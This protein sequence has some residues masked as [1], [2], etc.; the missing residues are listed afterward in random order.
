MY[1]L[2]NKI[3]EI[4]Q[5]I[6][7]FSIGFGLIDCF[8]GYRHFKFIIALNGFVFGSV[9]GGILGLIGAMYLEISNEIISIVL[10][11][12]F[13]CGI[14]T[15]LIAF[16]T[17]KLGVFIMGFSITFVVAFVLL[18]SDMSVFHLLFLDEKDLLGYAFAASIPSVIMG[19]I[20]VL[21]IKPTVIL[22]TAIIGAY[23]IAWGIGILI[24][25]N[26]FCA[27]ATIILAVIGSVIQFSSNN[28]TSIKRTSVSNKIDFRYEP[29][30]YITAV[31]ETTDVK[32]Y[33]DDE[34][35]TVL[36]NSEDVSEIIAF[37][38]DYTP[39]IAES[40][41]RFSFDIKKE[42]NSDTY[43]SLNKNEHSCFSTP[44]NL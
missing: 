14:I 2:L 16:F 4:L 10:F 21:F 35:I 18:I 37:E 1:S 32:S 27:I 36:P 26:S 42:T 25:D 7:L 6:G 11:T 40:K 13:V 44:D 24:D 30:P 15:A 28:N 17:Y 12:G 22:T 23:E 41:L 19:G 38:S 20:A 34:K 8:F 31:S 3:N 39:V 33:N 9:I 29:I 43:S 5:I